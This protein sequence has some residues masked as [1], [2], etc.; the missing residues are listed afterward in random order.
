MAKIKQRVF[1]YKPEWN[2]SSEEFI[3]FCSKVDFNDYIYFGEVTV[4]FDAPNKVDVIAMQIDAIDGSIQKLRAEFHV[5]VTQL[6][7]KKQS[8]LALP[9]HSTEREQE[10]PEPDTEAFDAMDDAGHKPTDF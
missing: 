2:L 10:T 8:L 1:A 4:E 9:N 7:E 5:K 6:E 3:F